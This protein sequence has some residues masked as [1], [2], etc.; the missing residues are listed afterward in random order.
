VEKQENIKEH[1][2]VQKKLYPDFFGKRSD[3]EMYEAQYAKFSQNQDLKDMLIFTKNAKLV[4]HRRAQEPE[5]F[6]N[7]MIIR[8]KLVKD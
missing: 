1:F 4:H 3:K 6:D 8:D 5:T 2:Y 7:L